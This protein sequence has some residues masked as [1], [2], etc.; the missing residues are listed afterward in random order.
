MSKKKI[1]L[2]TLNPTLAYCVLL[3]SAPS[4]FRITDMHAHRLAFTVLGLLPLLL[5][6]VCCGYVGFICWIVIAPVGN[7]HFHRHQFSITV[8]R[9]DTYA[10]QFPSDRLCVPQNKAFNLSIIYVVFLEFD[11]QNSMIFGDLRS[12][13]CGCAAELTNISIFNIAPPLSCVLWTFTIRHGTIFIV[14]NLCR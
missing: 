4:R 10:R 1:S 9:F 12:S 6:C 5:L 3:C 14:Y 8:T 11:Y 7:F 13:S 2:R